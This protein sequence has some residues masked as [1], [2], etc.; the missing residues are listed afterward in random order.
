M[1][2]FN[3]PLATETISFEDKEK[4]TN[5][6]KSN[7]KLT[8][9]DY[10]KKMEKLFAKFHNVKYCTMVNSGSSANLIMIASLYYH[11]ERLLKS[12]DEI[13][14]PSLGWSTSYSPIMQFGIT[15]IFI[16]VDKDTFNIDVDKIENSVTKKTKAILVINILG[17]PSNYKKIKKI[18]K[19]YNLLIIE[20][21][22][23][24]LG[25]KYQNKLTGT[26]GLMSTSSS[27]F[28]HHISTIEGGYI[29]TN[30]KYINALNKS[31][32]SHGWLRDPS[33]QVLYKKK[34]NK[35]KKNFTFI[36][37][38]YNVRSTEINA[39]LGILQMK[40]I[41]K[42]I[43]IRRKNFKFFKDLIS[44]TN[45]FKLQKETYES[46]WFGFGI[47]YKI[48]NKEKFKNVINF[49]IKN[50]IEIRPIVSG[51]FT[52][53]PM[54]M[55]SNVKYKLGKLENIK[56]INNFGFMIGNNPVSLNNETKKNFDRVFL[57]LDK[58]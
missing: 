54:V 24:S 38:G 43:Q 33:S 30:S 53:Q 55:N 14:V 17:N 42:Y 23:E 39:F 46:S 26:F 29:L 41:R 28:S 3:Y 52:Q 2:K 18:A 48:E 34:I 8:Q 25:A 56:K 27:F 57:Y 35:F 22:C 36:T 20:D 16:D 21:N 50:K 31:L 4:L 12:N 1:S 7:N 5:F 47:V 32:R 49:L 45:N 11:K 37:P 15:P 51:D 9:G 19:K 58:I 13:I 44:K 40:R 10:V 6:I